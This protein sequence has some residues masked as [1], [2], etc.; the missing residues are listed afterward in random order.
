MKPGNIIILLK[1]AQVIVQ[2]LMFII[3]DKLI[4][5]IDHVC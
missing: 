4:E 2:L 3:V 5:K 1:L